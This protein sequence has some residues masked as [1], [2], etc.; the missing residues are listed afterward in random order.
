MNSAER[1][2]AL[3]TGGARGIGEGI[4][5]DLASDHDI[6]FSFNASTSRA[7]ALQADL[8]SAHGVQV[9]FAET[10]AADHLISET[11]SHF[12]RLDVVVNNASLGKPN[13][14]VEGDPSLYR[15]MFE[16]NVFF[17]VALIRAALPHLTGHGRIANISSVNGQ[18]P[19]AAAGAF[20]ATKAALEAWS[21]AMAKELGPSNIRVNCVSP[22][23]ILV[24]D[25]ER[26]AEIMSKIT[27]Q[28]PLGKIGTVDDV[29]KAVRYL[30]T[31]ASS[32]VTGECIRVAGGYGR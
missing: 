30:A 24:D 20:A 12:G 17:P 5:R 25:V 7:K 3:V 23:V 21:V 29:A 28:T 32:H 31:D 10:G 16:T 4:V 15:E 18:F 13:S 14:T 22:G 8:S 19:P 11:L 26:P 27:D 2:V 6:V 9:D 1:A